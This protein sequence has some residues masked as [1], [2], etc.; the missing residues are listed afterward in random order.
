LDV[1]QE[2]QVRTA[3]VNVSSL[4]QADGGDIELV[5]FDPDQGSVALRLVVDGATCQEC[6]L[7]RPLLEDISK[8][9]LQRSVPEITAVSIEDPREDPNFVPETH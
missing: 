4:V 5:S 7:P 8:G 6:I 9:I 3:L 1:L 2:D